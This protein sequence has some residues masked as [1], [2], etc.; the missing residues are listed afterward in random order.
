MV[1]AVKHLIMAV[2][3]KIKE[4]PK[5]VTRDPASQSRRSQLGFLD[6]DL[7]ASFNGRVR[8]AVVT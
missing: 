6:F 5:L 1:P 3:M 2:S 8:M 7:E 4:K